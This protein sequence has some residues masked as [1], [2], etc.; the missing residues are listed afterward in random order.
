MSVY[1]SEEFRCNIYYIAEDKNDITDALSRLDINSTNKIGT[2]E[3]TFWLRQVFKDNIE[4]PI[5]YRT[6]KQTS[7][8]WILKNM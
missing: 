7:S 2:V 8:D 6:S 5:F 1:I 3:D 4:I